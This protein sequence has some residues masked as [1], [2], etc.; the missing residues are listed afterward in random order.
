MQ[1]LVNVL[2]DGDDPDTAVGRPRLHPVGAA[3]HVEPGHPGEH[4]SALAS[5]G[6]EV[7]EWADRDHYFGG[8]TAGGEDGAAGDPRRGGAGVTL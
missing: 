6:F 5:A 2:L 4:L 7:V 1:T 8:V 3:V